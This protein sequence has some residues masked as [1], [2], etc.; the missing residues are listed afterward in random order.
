MRMTILAA[1]VALALA[2]CIVPDPNA[3]EQ[4]AILGYCPQWIPGPGQ[5]A[6]TANLNA[7]SPQASHPFEAP[8]AAVG[9]HALDIYRIRIDRIEVEGGRLQMHALVGD[10]GTGGN[11]TGR[12]IYDFRQVPFKQVP[13]LMLFGHANETKQDFDVMVNDISQSAPTQ[14]HP[15]R[16]DWT[17]L[18]AEEGVGRA[19][20][21]YH[22]TFHYRVCGAA[23][24]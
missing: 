1:F 17:F 13:S 8:E 12:S 22:V 16:L 9:R 14:A 2:G 24:A 6:A 19:L 21:E 23:V 3:Q 20:V 7:S 11:A 18:P 15:L 10:E 4:E 5:E